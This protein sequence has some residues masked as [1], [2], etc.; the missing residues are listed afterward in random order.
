MPSSDIDPA[1]VGAAIGI[2]AT[3]GTRYQFTD[4]YRV[5]YTGTPAHLALSALARPDMTADLYPRQPFIAEGLRAAAST[6]I[7]WFTSPH[8]VPR[9]AAEFAALSP[10]RVCELVIYL[11]ENVAIADLKKIGPA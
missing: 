11:Y 1:L 3:T 10:M 5:T 4:A 9:H 6:L 7:D 2:D 8:V